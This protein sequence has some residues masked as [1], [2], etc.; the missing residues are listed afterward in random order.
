MVV[1]KLTVEDRALVENLK[2]FTMLDAV[3]EPLLLISLFLN[4][5]MLVVLET[6]IMGFLAEFLGP[7]NLF[8]ID[9]FD[10]IY[11]LLFIQKLLLLQ[12]SNRLVPENDGIL[13][14]LANPT[15]FILLLSIKFPRTERCFLEHRELLVIAKVS[16]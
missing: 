2:E 13:L 8:G 10:A 7:Q 9:S 11:Y 5:L 14:F 4:F 12:H 16:L 1:V 3:F 15:F 6:Y